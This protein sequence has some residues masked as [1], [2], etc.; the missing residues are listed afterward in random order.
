MS[1]ISLDSISSYIDTAKKTSAGSDLQK[2]LGKDLS[3]ASDEELMDVCK[4][5]EAYFV[6]QVLKEAEKMVP[7]SDEDSSMSQLT[8]FYKDTVRQEM[9]SKIGE[10]SGTSFAQMMYEQMKRNYNL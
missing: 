10:Q 4:E 3:T 9:A 8:D 5:F 2:T 7:D 6:E 1:G